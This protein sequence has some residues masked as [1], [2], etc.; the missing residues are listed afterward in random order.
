MFEKNK[1]SDQKETTDVFRPMKGSAKV[2]IGN[3]VSLKGE[4]TKADEVQIDGEADIIVKADNLVVGASGNCK[5]TIETHNA[6]IW[7]IFDGDM[8]A[9]GTLT[10]QE[11]GTVA[12]TVEYQNLQ[13]KLGGK[14]SGDVKLSDKIK[15]IKEE[16]KEN[17]SSSNKSL[18][19]AIKKEK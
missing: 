6:D 13:I 11:A 8:K 5:G 7:G 16:V 17:N 4:I 12:G 18:H 3:G 2:V 10:I 1:N 9:S 14:I 15:S 19:E